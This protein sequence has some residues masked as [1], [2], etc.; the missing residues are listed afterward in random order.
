MKLAKNLRYLRKKNGFS[1]DYI[2]EKLG[3]KSYTTIQKWEMGTSEPS[4]SI[5]KKLSKI[6]NVDMD[7]IY[8][9]DLE[10][11]ETSNKLNH[12]KIPLLGEIAAG[13]PLLAEE[14]IE[15][16]FT[17]DGKIKADFA[18]RVKGD[19]MMGAGIFPKDIVFIRKQNTLENGEIGA[20]LIENEA[21]LKKFYK[22]KSTIVLQ[23]ENDFYKPIICNFLPLQV[24][25]VRILPYL[26]LFY[27][28][29]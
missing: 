8:T 18:L 16:Y 27:L 7:S 6:Y 23:P 19:S 24:L 2:A 12:R 9:K 21:T 14:N 1:Q 3:Y 4:I 13:Y 11:Y 22:E 17:I 29:N 15:D 25:Y 26:K 5:L 10:V 20:V 28:S